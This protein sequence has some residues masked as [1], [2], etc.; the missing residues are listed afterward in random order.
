MSDK[1]Q[2]K[3][4][5]RAGYVVRP[6]TNGGF[7]IEMGSGGIS[8]GPSGYRPMLAAFTNSSD[9]MAFL[10]KGHAE[11]DKELANV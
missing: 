7:V 5:A 4:F 10:A 1:Y 6:A 9:M 3:D 8:S 2:A 11:F